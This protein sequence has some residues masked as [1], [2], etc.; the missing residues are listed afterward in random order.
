MSDE[1][2]VREPVV[3]HA[4]VTPDLTDLNAVRDFVGEITAAT[5]LKV[6]FTVDTELM[7]ADVRIGAGSFPLHVPGGTVILVVSTVVYAL[8][9]LKINDGTS[10]AWITYPEQER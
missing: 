7:A 2:A 9:A 10:A 1:T 5:R 4:F 6:T 8:D 3:G